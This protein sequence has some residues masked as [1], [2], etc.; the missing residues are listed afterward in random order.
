LPLIKNGRMLRHNMRKEF[1]TE[2]EVRSQL[3]QQQI[4]DVAAV[5]LAHLEP[6]GSISVVRANGATKTRGQSA[7]P[8]HRAGV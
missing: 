1:I 4:E 6:D 7:K 8:D 5:R 3:R 2:D